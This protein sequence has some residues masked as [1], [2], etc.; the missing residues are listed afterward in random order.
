[1]E[2]DAFILLPLTLNKLST[3][4]AMKPLTG[5]YKPVPFL[6]KYAALYEKNY[7]D[8]MY[9]L[10]IRPVSIMEDISIIYSWINKPRVLGSGHISAYQRNMLKYYKTILDSST[11]QSFM[12]L[13]DAQPVCQLDIYP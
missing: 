10:Q 6:I 3:N 8:E 4:P 11:S 9:T 7:P 13:K 2:A 12:V 1:M 5:L